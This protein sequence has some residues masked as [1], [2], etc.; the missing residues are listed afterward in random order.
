[1]LFIVLNQLHFNICKNY[2]VS[3]LLVTW[4]QDLSTGCSKTRWSRRATR[5]PCPTG[6]WG[7]RAGGLW[8]GWRQLS[9][10]PTT[11]RPTCSAAGSFGDLTRAGKPTRWSGI[12]RRTIHET[13]PSG[14]SLPIRMTS[15]AGGMVNQISD[16]HTRGIDRPWWR[17]TPPLRKYSSA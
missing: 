13:P 14:K 1:M 17:Y 9:S 4:L 12:R 5:G 16:I 3:A 10:G 2:K 6:A 7:R 15:S 11:A 8:T